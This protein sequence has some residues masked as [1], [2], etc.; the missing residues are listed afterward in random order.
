M[1]TP[2][3]HGLAEPGSLKDLEPAEPVLRYEP[4]T[5]GQIIHIDI[6]KL[7]RFERAGRRITGN[8]RSQSALRGRR[9]GGPYPSVGIEPPN[10]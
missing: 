9:Q 10:Y 6:K 7:G 3:T 5:P 1:H 8:R 4:K 2:N